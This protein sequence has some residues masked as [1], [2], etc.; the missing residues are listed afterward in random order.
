MFEFIHV[1][2]QYSNAV[3]VAVL[4]YITD[5]S[6]KLNLSIVA[7]VTPSQVLSFKCDPR[8]DHIGGVI[9]LTN[10]FEFTFL[11]GRVCVYRSPQSYFSLQEPDLVPKF[12]GP[13]KINKQK[14]LEVAHDVIRKLGYTDQMF[15]ADRVPQITLPEKV[16]T[17][18]V[19][20]Y[21]FQWLD[22]TWRGSKT[23]VPSLLTVEVNASNSRIEMMSITSRETQRPSPKVD[24]EPAP[25]R[26]AEQPQLR[27]DEGR[28]TESINSAYAEAFLN[29]ILPQV[30]EFIIKAGLSIATP[31]TTNDVDISQYI[32]TLDRGNP[33]A[34][35]Y[36]KSGDRFNYTHG[37][38]TAF[39]AHDAFLKFPDMGKVEDFL[40]KI[41]MNTNDAITLAKQVVKKL[42]Y[43]D[44]RM[45]TGF[46]APIYVGTDKFT[47]YFIHF[48]R[49][50]DNSYIAAFEI[51]LESKTIKSVYL[52]DPSLWREPP[53][54]DVPIS[55][56]PPKET[57]AAP[58][59]RAVT[60]AANGPKQDWRIFQPTN[61]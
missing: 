18:Y 34:Q 38:V 42:G 60:P 15:H 47:R 53:K 14:A 25:L 5:F 19:A 61:P 6:H 55:L 9:T 4:P 7:P 48:H 16:G 36:L 50:E 26:K 49:P 59:K 39:Y 46:G 33:N 1:T 44:R 22:P 27:Q 17:N 56:P 40:G 54:I 51:D 32:C 43:T 45:E 28:K 12:Y 37:H 13:V 30:S 21:M 2:A 52:D 3:L 58:A 8:K 41:N 31:L 57:N 23:I 29:A 20:R 24:V 35:L 11:D 10:H